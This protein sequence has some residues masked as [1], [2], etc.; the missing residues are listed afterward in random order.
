M[1]PSLKPIDSMALTSSVE[2]NS[3]LK[4]VEELLVC[5][6][7]ADDTIVSFLSSSGTLGFVFCAF[8]NFSGLHDFIFNEGTDSAANTLFSKDDDSV[9][10]GDATVFEMPLFWDVT[11]VSTM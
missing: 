7:D 6:I 2:D 10:A 11:A 8:S 5:D 4:S 9:A 3:V 1:L